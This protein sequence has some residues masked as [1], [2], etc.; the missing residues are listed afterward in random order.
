LPIATASC[1]AIYCSHILEHLSLED[2][3]TALTNTAQYLKPTGVFRLVVPD[4]EQLARAYLASAVEQPAMQF[5]EESH[6]G[7]QRRPRGFGGVVREWLGNSRHLWMWDYRSLSAEL[8]RA[9]FRHIRRASF[10]DAEHRQFRDVEEPG[11]WEN[12][13]GIEC[14]SERVISR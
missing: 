1:E 13:L 2:L 6:L 14:R 8:N 11:R 3:R 9:G 10:G 5:M 12:C 7:Y 4:L